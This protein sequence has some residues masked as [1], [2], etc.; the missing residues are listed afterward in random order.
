LAILVLEAKDVV[1]VEA[2]V[3]IGPKVLKLGE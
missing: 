1:I 2:N 3:V